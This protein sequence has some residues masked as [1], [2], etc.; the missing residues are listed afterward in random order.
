MW[1][2]S[3]KFVG[4][5]RQISEAMN[6]AVRVHV[7]NMNDLIA[8]ISAYGAGDL[9]PVMRQLPGKQAHAKVNLDMLRDNVRALIRDTRRWYRRLSPGNSA[10]EPT[11]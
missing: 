5:Y 9:T 10:P 11:P 6:D 7:S 3:E 8:C 4:A 1:A 2:N